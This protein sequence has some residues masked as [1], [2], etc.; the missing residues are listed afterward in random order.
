MRA[1]LAVFQKGGIFAGIGGAPR[2]NLDKKS[3]ESMDE[4]KAGHRAATDGNMW[5]S[6]GFVEQDGLRYEQPLTVSSS[7]Y[8]SADGYCYLF[9]FPSYGKLHLLK[10]LKPGCAGVAFYEKMLQKEFSIGYQLDHPNIRRT[11]GWENVD[12][13]GHGIVLEYV[14]GITLRELMDSGKLTRPLSRKLV[15]ELCGALQYMHSKQIVHRDLKPENILITHNGQNVKLIDFS[16]SD[17]DDSY[18]LK[19]PAGTKRYMAPELLQPASSWD[20]RC[21][22]YSLG[23]ILREM[24]VLLHD[25]RL[26]RVA[27][28]CMQP[29]KEKRYADAAAVVEALQARSSWRWGV[30][31]VAVVVLLA[32][33]QLAG[34]ME[35][36]SGETDFVMPAARGNS[37]IAPSCRQILF[38]E[39]GRM[40][41]AGTYAAQDS[42]RLMNRLR[43]ALDR[44]Y[45][46]PEQ[47]QSAAYRQEWRAI[48]G[49]VRLMMRRER[50]P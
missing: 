6:S 49:E 29:D 41:S 50:I 37:V 23:V 1:C 34:R 44:V 35:A 16:L 38:E 9:S 47:K 13:L 11:L 5:D 4:H 48:S 18:L 21:D 15:R 39:F 33:W 7:F 19:V 17:C 40:Q 14:D 10:T 26:K 25:R 3:I 31:A 46:L 28:V 20:F 24:G 22:L 30:A 36:S 32:G 43:Q 2:T 8:A 12:G 45:P 27:S 42:V